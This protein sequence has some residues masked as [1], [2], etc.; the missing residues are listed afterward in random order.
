MDIL[1]LE[2]PENFLEYYFQRQCEPLDYC[3]LTLCGLERR[4]QSLSPFP[5][6]TYTA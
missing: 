6:T 2:N 4:S 1:F 3:I 5:V